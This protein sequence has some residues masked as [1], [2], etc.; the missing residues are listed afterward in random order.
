MDWILDNL[1]LVVV[2]A[3]AF[4]VWLTQRRKQA[5]EDD[6]PPPVRPTEDTGPF[7]LESEARRIQ[8]EIRRKIAER[9]GGSAEMPAPP[10]L[11][12]E[13]EG[14]PR[15]VV[16][17]PVPAPRTA[18]EW[19]QSESLV[20]ENQRRMQEQM[21]ELAA[22]RRAARQQAAQA[23]AYPPAPG[24]PGKSGRAAKPVAVGSV[25]AALR[26]PASVRQAVLLREVLGAPVALQ[27]R[28]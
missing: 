2:L 5:Q 11:P 10:P 6:S 3:S 8:E 16:T 20:L 12:F 9:R 22:Q 24:Q 26:S 23:F 7:D 15:T 27:R 21:R 25:R 18:P 17:A 4:A 28:G 1:Q 19:D 13:R 14:R